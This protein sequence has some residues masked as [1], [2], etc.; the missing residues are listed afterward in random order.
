MVGLEVLRKSDILGGLSDEELLT[1]AKMAREEIYDA[2][3]VIFR[4]N[5]PARDFYIVH[6]GRVAVL[7][8]VD[9]DEQA[10][11][12]IVNRDQSFGWCALIPPYI[13]NSTAKTLDRARLIVISARAFRGLRQMDCCI[14]C[15]VMEKVSALIFHRL[16]DVRW[17]L[18]GLMSHV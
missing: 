9:K 1:I 4:E 3:V 11:I 13:R 2:G 18:L 14:Y 10:L 12:S 6:E 16:A 7:I 17:Q 5:E 15:S 8:D